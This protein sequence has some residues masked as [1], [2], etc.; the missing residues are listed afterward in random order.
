MSADEGGHLLQ[1]LRRPGLRN[2]AD[3]AGVV[4]RNLSRASRHEDNDNALVA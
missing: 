2:G 4:G 1:S 3:R